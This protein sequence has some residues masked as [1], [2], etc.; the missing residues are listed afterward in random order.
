[1]TGRPFGLFEMGGSDPGA[2]P[3][4][5]ER[6]RDHEGEGDDEGPFEAFDE[7]PDPSEQQRKDE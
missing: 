7:K 5:G 2:A 3:V 6:T 4:T 1:V